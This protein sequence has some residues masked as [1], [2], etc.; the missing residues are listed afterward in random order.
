MSNK[1]KNIFFGLISVCV[2][3]LLGKYA[4][5]HTTTQYKQQLSFMLEDEFKDSI[6][7][8]KRLGHNEYVGKLTP[9]NLGFK[10]SL[11]KAINNDPL[12]IEIMDLYFSQVKVAY[13]KIAYEIDKKF[14]LYIINPYNIDNYLFYIN[15]GH[16]EYSFLDDGGE[17]K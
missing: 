3:V 7:E 2:I 5:D 6:I 9:T 4:F 11:E 12:N 14:D 10:N 13:D 16:I 15:D 1:I 17:L 8:V